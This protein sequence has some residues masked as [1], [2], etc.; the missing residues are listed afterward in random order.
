M[1]D[2]LNLRRKGGASDINQQLYALKE[3]NARLKEMAGK[4]SEVEKLKL[5]NKMMK[6]EI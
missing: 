3:E 6:L 2:I 1:K 5:E 4:I